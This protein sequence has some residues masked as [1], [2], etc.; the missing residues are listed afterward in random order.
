MEQGKVLLRRHVKNSKYD[1]QCDEVDLVESNP[2]YARVR[3]PN[4]REKSVSLRDLAPMPSLTQEIP[5][6]ISNN[7]PCNDVSISEPTVTSEPM[8]VAVPPTPIEASES[9][10]STPPPYPVRQ[11][12]RVRSE[13]T[14]LDYQ[15]L[16][17]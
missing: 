13:P 4:G 15:K 1:D 6:S 10:S 8:T 16:G 17:G 12:Q 2:S 14:R 3:L 7:N 5:N 11:S 9:V